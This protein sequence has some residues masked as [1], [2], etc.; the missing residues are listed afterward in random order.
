MRHVQYSRCTVLPPH[1]KKIYK[2]DEVHE[3]HPRE[4]LQTTLV[5]GKAH[6]FPRAN[7]YLVVYLARYFRTVASRWK[8]LSA[9][10]LDQD[11]RGTCTVHGTYNEHALS[12]FRT[13]EG[14]R[15]G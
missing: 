5:R 3:R 11:V 12:V 7:V 1:C 2:R 9:E 6:P 10:S 15:F 8:C 14:A 13:K 4:N